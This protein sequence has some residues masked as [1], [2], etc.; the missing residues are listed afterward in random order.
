MK[1]EHKLAIVGIPIRLLFCSYSLFETTVELFLCVIRVI[2]TV[3]PC[4]FF[5][6]KLV[7]TDFVWRQ[8][9]VKQSI[10][11]FNY[12]YFFQSETL[13]FPILVFSYMQKDRSNPNWWLRSHVC[14]N[15]R[16]LLQVVYHKNCTSSD[17]N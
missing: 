3:K 16:K 8:F 6:R 15:L 7:L 10:E 13:L 5:C 11:L 4:L 2:E 17:G 12:A 14:L 9:S 1:E